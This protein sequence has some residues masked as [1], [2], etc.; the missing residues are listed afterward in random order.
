MI[1]FSRTYREFIYYLFSNHVNKL[2]H[3]KLLMIEHIDAGFFMATLPVGDFC[4]RQW[5]RLGLAWPQAC[6]R[7]C[8]TH[9]AH[10][11][12][13]GLH[14][15]STHGRAECVPT[16]LHYSL[17]PCWM[18]LEFLSCVWEKWGYSDNWRLSMAE[19]NFTE[20]LNSYPQKG[21]WGWPPRP[22]VGWSFSVWL[23]LGLL[24]AQNGAACAGW[25]VSMQETKT[26]ISFKGWKGSMKNQLGKGRFM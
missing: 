22:E 6:R 13:P 18:V 17:Y 4:G 25:F 23:G 19:K 8:Y 20:Q 14:T 24:W 10:W 11:A 3:S 1:F 21:T 26:K 9:L 2:I 7:R 12:M 5:P 15:S 16:S